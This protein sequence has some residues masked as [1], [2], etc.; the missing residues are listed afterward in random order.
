MYLR[1][2]LYGS[3]PALLVGLALFAKIPPLSQFLR[4][5][6]FHLYEKRASPLKRDLA[7]DYP[8]S[9]LGGLEISM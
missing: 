7:I 9:R 4:K 6:C 3:E 8:R 5:I 1:R 2:C